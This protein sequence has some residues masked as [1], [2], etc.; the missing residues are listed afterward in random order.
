MLS[1]VL[2]PKKLQKIIRQYL[3][4]YAFS[5]AGGEEL[6]DLIDS[7]YIP[8]NT[9]VK[10]IMD[11]WF[12]QAGFPLITVTRNYAR[13]TVEVKQVNHFLIFDRTNA[14]FYLNCYFQRKD[15]SRITNYLV[16][17]RQNGGSL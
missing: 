9:D 14:R 1:H 15:S 6:L 7:Q 12:S 16:R 8:P 4:K 10:T 5:N 17:I 3:K 2:G 13:A 11:T